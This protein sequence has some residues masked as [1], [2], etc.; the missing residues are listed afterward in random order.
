MNLDTQLRETMQNFAG[1][2]S[3]DPDVLGQVSRRYRRFRRTRWLAMAA[4]STLVVFAVTFGAGIVPIGSSKPQL[5][6]AM[7][8]LSPATVEQAPLPFPYEFTWLPAG[9]HHVSV[10]WIGTTAMATILI[11]G[12]SANVTLGTVP[13]EDVPPGGDELDASVNG[14]DARLRTGAVPDEGGSFAALTWPLGDTWVTID[15][16]NGVGQSEVVHIAHGMRPGRTE[17]EVP[18]SLRWAPNGWITSGVTHGY[19]TSLTLESHERFLFS[20]CLADPADKA[21]SGRRLCVNM[22]PVREPAESLVGFE[23][24]T[25]NGRT[26]WLERAAHKATLRLVFELGDWRVTVVN[27]GQPSMSERDLITFAEGISL[28][29]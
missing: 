19:A 24:V 6:Q 3:V 26:S 27:S 15:G 16:R 8:E 5:G 21:D 20:H 18:I 4:G 29:E 11:E 9:R 7:L 13:F 17:I 28:V 12:G 23:A 2:A 25:V 10:T 22:V 14:I 1:A